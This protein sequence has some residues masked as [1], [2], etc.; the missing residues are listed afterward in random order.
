MTTTTGSFKDQLQAWVDAATDKADRVVVKSVIELQN[1]IKIRTPVDTGRL[2]ANWQYSVDRIPTGVLAL[3]SVLAAAPGA[4][5]G[6]FG[7]VHYIT[8]NLPYARR[9]EF[10]F[11]GADSLGRVYNQAGRNMVGLSVL[12]WQDIVRSAV[13]SE[14]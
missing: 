7:R 2:R 14:A 6:S 4:F 8:N 1:R 10:G 9:I 3:G 13:A 12:E 11:H 5:S